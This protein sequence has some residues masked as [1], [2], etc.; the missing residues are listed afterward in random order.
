[1]SSSEEETKIRRQARDTCARKESYVKGQQQERDLRGSQLSLSI[2]DFQLPRTVRKCIF[3]LF[4]LTHLFRAVP[5]NLSLAVVSVA[6]WYRTLDDPMDC[7]CQDALSM[8]FLRQEYWRGLPFPSP[9]DLPD[10]GSNLCLL[11]WREDFLPLSYQGSPS[12][13]MQLHTVFLLSYLPTPLFFRQS[14][15]S[16]IFL[17]LKNK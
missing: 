11:H 8:V 9:G 15:F 7:S 13:L 4:K 14:T 3:L 16:R 6:K 12:K 17:K 1:M 5:V 2:L 10:P